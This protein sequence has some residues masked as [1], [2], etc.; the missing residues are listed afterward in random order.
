M[1]NKLWNAAYEIESLIRAGIAPRPV[2]CRLRV[3]FGI[4]VSHTLRNWRT[5]NRLY[6][7]AADGQLYPVPESMGASSMVRMLND[8]RLYLLTNGIY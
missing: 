5:R 2:F 4:S 6:L 7:R 8:G 1:A 3:V